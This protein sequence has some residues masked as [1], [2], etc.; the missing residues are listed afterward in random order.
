MARRERVDGTTLP[1]PS[2][3]LRLRQR[4][5]D[6]VTL[7][8]LP[9]VLF[10]LALFV[11]PFLYG[12]FLS[13]APKQ[14][15]L[16]ANYAKFFSNAFL[17]DTISTTLLIAIPATLVN[18]VLSIP[19][20]M[21]VRLMR[22]QRLLTTIL[23]IPITLGTVLVAEGLLT[24]L[25]PRG[26]VNRMLVDSGITDSPIRLVHN[27]WG[28]LLSLVI[29]GF[30]FSFLLTLSYVTGIDPSLEHA[31]AILGARARERFLRIVLPLLAPGLAITLALSFVQAFSVFPSAILL[32]APAGPTRVI[33]IAAYQAAF[34]QYDYSMA[35]A[36]AMIMAAVQVVIVVLLLAARG[37]VFRGPASSGKG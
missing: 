16:F 1:A 24:Y 21:R 9:C 12:L 17:Y 23:V 11:Y 22:W 10:V 18:V 15:G 37:L 34:E 25:G 30:P 29:S 26:W 14:G 8:V 5:L 36:I 7:L 4:G 13:F 6:G 31:G 19:I 35:S 3:R 2:L 33:S 20:A 32:G 27:Y 28:V